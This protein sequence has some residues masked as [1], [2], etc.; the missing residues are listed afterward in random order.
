MKPKWIVA[1]ILASVVAG[2]ASLET[3]VHAAQ[4]P[5]DPWKHLA[6]KQGWILLAYL[7]ENNIIRAEAKY[8]V[9]GFKEP[10]ARV[11]KVPVP[12]DYI[13]VGEFIKLIILDFGTKGQA[14][15]SEP[16]VS[17]GR[18]LT[19]NDETGVVF[20]P[21]TQVRVEEVRAGFGGRYQHVW[22]KVAP[23]SR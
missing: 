18:P 15:L 17:A 5:P 8:D 9:L 16:P 3:P 19:F 10:Q 22:A 6:T 7:D 23:A 2:M 21:G 1:I 4:E 11:S 14:R 12:G 20:A 13:R